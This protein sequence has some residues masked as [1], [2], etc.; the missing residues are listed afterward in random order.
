MENTE[1][2]SMNSSENPEEHKLTP[3]E[4]EEERGIELLEDE[5]QTDYSYLKID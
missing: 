4:R 1:Q 2:I 5:R 3:E